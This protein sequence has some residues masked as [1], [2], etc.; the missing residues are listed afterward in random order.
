M[1]FPSHSFSPPVQAFIVASE[2]LMSPA[3]LSHD[4]TPEERDIIAEYVMMLSGA[5]HPWSKELAVR[6]P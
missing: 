3:A 4:F 1:D 5:K 2:T 6:Y